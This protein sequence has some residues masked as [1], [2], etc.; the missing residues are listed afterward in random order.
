M[1]PPRRQDW[2]RSWAA[3]SFEMPRTKDLFVCHSSARAAPQDEAEHRPA[4]VSDSFPTRH[5]LGCLAEHDLVRE[6]V[7]A[8]IELRQ[9]Q[10]MAQREENAGTRPTRRTVI[11][12]G[13][14]LLGLARARANPDWPHRPIPILP[15]FPP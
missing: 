7:P 13:L 12:G 10:V 1:R 14:S 6:P 11:A 2:R 3:P 5:A 4:L 15:G 8:R 9:V